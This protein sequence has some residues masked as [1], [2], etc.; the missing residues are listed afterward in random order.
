MFDDLDD[1]ADAFTH[2]Q[3]RIRSARNEREL[4]AC[5]GLLDA[6]AFL[7]LPEHCQQDLLEQYVDKLAEIGA[8]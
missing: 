7:A 3:R 6:P 5:T 1:A 2:I 4:S 8:L